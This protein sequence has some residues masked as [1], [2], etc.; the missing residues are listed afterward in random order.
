M[1][2]L[3]GLT[4]SMKANVVTGRFRRNSSMGPKLIKL[5]LNFLQD[6]YY[7]Y[8]MYDMHKESL[9]TPFFSYY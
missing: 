5:T 3:S 1:S 4:A 9:D 2:V 8:I 6:K 7:S